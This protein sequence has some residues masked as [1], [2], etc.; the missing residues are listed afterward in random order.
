M[1]YIAL[2]R[3]DLLVSR[4]AFGAEGLCQAGSAEDAAGLVR[5]AYDS[6]VNFFDTAH[7]HTDCERL[8]G[9]ALYGVRQNVIVAT[10]TAS[11]SAGGVLRDLE[12]SLAALQTDVIDLYQLENPQTLPLPGDA[13][14][15]YDVLLDAKKQGK[16]RHIGIA[17]ESMET[18]VEAVESGCYETLQFPFHMLLPEETDSIVKLCLQHDV[19]FIAM[20]PLCGG[21][22]M[23]IPLAFGFLR[24]YENVVP[25]WGVKTHDELQQILFFEAHPPLVD[26]AFMNDVRAQRSFFS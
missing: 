18:A 5:A 12:E 19:G 25:V 23:N 6:G 20:R 8:L 11:A 13:G 21:L 16:I 3:S 1:E 22:L 17:A 9:A 26:E 10:K 2:G 15:V 7:N 24:Q 4:T 14:G